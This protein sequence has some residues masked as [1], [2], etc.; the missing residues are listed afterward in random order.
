MVIYLHERQFLFYFW[1]S[2]QSR[3]LLAGNCTWHGRII[4]M[5]IVL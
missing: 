4:S 3:V 5:L 1:I 2:R